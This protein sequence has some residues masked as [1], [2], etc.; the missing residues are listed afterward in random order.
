MLIS[1]SLLARC[2]S[3]GPSGYAFDSRTIMTRAVGRSFADAMPFFDANRVHAVLGTLESPGT[4]ISLR[5]PVGRSFSVEDCV[6]SGS[7]TP[8]AAQFLS[9]MIEAR[10]AFSISGGIGSGTRG[11]RAVK[12][13]VRSVDH[14]SPGDCRKAARAC[15]CV[16]DAIRCQIA[17]I[18]A[19][20]RR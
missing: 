18:Q 14:L 5:V 3:N 10:L 1:G 17:T 16:P 15:A 19:S 7:L 8:G 9:R 13:L 2:R 20:I 6:A 11:P 12:V 4:C